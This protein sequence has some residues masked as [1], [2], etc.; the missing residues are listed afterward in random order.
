MKTNLEIQEK[1][2]D[3]IQNKEEYVEWLCQNQTEKQLEKLLKQLEGMY[4][5]AELEQMA[6][7]TELIKLWKDQVISALKNLGNYGECYAILKKIRNSKKLTQFE[8]WLA[9]NND[10]WYSKRI[11]NPAKKEFEP[12]KKNEGPFKNPLEDAQINAEVYIE[13]MIHFDDKKLEKH[14]EL[15]RQQRETA[16]KQQNHKAVELLDLYERQVIEA[17]ILK[18]ELGNFQ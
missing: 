15:F 10:G 8:R 7:H 14:L 9:S 2:N 13:Q 12:L 5:C 4:E 11:Y 3:C 18:M 17:R 6:N 16:F 1:I